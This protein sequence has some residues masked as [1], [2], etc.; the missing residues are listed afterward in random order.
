MRF[1]AAI[2]LIL[3]GCVSVVG[4]PE[5]DR[6]YRVSPRVQMAAVAQLWC[7]DPCA[8]ITMSRSP[9]INA[10]I[11]IY[12]RDM[13][14]TRAMINYTQSDDELAFVIAH[15]LA[16]PVIGGGATTRWQELAA[17]ALAVELVIR[18]R[19]DPQAGIAL[20]RRLG[21]EFEW[22]NDSL[23]PTFEER[24]RIMESVVLQLG[25]RS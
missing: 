23:Y 22:T 9:N 1:A 5:L 20:L 19:Y 24:V 4:T 25:E 11:N 6:L 7:S 3:V 15:E 17:D 14:V 2:L 13:T 10:E 12:S 21:N 18:A 8:N 16:H